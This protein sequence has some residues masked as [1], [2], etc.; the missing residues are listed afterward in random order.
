MK[1]V[2]ILLTFFSGLVWADEY[3]RSYPRCNPE[4][5]PVQSDCEERVEESNRVRI[6]RRVQHELYERYGGDR[7][8]ARAIRAWCEKEKFGSNNPRDWVRSCIIAV[9][10]DF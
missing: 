9:Q 4:Y 10:G 1:C 2:F 5:G 3:D 6:E 8:D 7:S